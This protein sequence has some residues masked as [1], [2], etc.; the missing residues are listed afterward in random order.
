[1]FSNFPNEERKPSL[2]AHSLFLTSNED[3]KNEF[4]VCKYGFEIVDHLAL[5]KEIEF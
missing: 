1:M 4:L 3:K 5:I 2:N